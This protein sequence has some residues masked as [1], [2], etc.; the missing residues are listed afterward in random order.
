MLKEWDEHMKD[1][2]PADMLRMTLDPRT[3]EEMYQEVI[4]VPT[5]VRGAFYLEGGNKKKID[6]E[7]TGPSG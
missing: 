5:K 6:F 2:E 3:V 7:I 4:A 1:F